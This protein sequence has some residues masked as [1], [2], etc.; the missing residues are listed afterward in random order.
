M[1]EPICIN[2]MLASVIL[3]ETLTKAY[4]AETSLLQADVRIADIKIL[5]FLHVGIIAL[6]AYFSLLCSLCLMLSD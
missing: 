5:S 6:S 3:M 2:W 4:Q 1:I